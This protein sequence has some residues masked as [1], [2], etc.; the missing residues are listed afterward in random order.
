[1]PDE[2]PKI[3][4]D[5]EQASMVSCW[6]EYLQLTRNVDG[7][8]TI[9]VCQYGPLANVADFTDENDELKLPDEI[10]GTPV[11]GV[12][13]EWII[14]GELVLVRELTYRD[15]PEALE[16]LREDG[17]KLTGDATVELSRVL[18]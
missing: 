5:R 17:W 3:I 4:A 6:N 9:A 18:R 10:D 8:A 2:Y 16:W 15:A 7:S 12:E 1:M 14:G 11:I 13:D